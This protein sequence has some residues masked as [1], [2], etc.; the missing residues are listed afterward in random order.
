MVFWCRIKTNVLKSCQTQVVLSTRRVYP[1]KFEDSMFGIPL[2]KRPQ[3]V[4]QPLPKERP[5]S[6]MESD[7]RDRIKNN[8]VSCFFFGV[9]YFDF[10]DSLDWKDQTVGKSTS[11]KECHL[12]YIVSS[13]I[14]FISLD[15]SK[16]SVGFIFCG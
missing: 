1:D 4:R 5:L 10:Q 12:L 15:L 13:S 9:R 6:L 2:I 16:T 7:H 3:L 11:S 8:I 14:Q